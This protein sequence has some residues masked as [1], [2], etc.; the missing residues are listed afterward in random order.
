M[1]KYFPKIDIIVEV[2]K[3]SIRLPG[4]V[5][6]KVCNKT[7]LELMI[8]RLKRIKVVK[9]IIIAT[10][11][12][13]KDNEIVAI[14]KK[15]N[16]KFF[17]GSEDDVLG[18]VLYAA[19][20]FKTEVIVEITGDTP[21]IDPEISDSIIKFFLKKKNQFDYVANDLGFH[22]RKYKMKSPLGL[23]VK[24]FSTKLLERINKMT[25]NSVDREHVANYIVKNP[26][27]FKLYNYK[28]SKKISRP[29]LRF[30]LDYVEDL[31]VIKKIYENLYYKN[32]LFKSH[33]IINF[34]DKNPRIKNL[35][36]NCIQQ[37]YIY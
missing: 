6:K 15:S 27:K 5:L 22:N 29:D 2:R 17:R 12:L 18:R 31:L 28:V 3:N 26:K 25:S 24:V 8:E 34:L 16:V 7:L 30:T 10:T 37:S 9:D 21:L 13:K 20:K 1:K 19:K 35:N 33:D 11:N 36:K 4:K 23:S 32:P 14:A